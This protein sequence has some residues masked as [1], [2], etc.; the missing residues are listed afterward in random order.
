MS[1]SDE[2]IELHEL[3]ERAQ[4]NLP[5]NDLGPFIDALNEEYQ[6]FMMMITRREVGRGI[7]R[8]RRPAV[9]AEAR[10]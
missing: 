3:C 5:W 4:K 7:P 9:K 2:R 8:S 10:S 6:A 1:Y